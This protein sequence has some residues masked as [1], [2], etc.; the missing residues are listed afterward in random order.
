MR[1]H[2]NTT[3]ETTSRDIGPDEAVE[4]DGGTALPPDSGGATA[5]AVPFTA[6]QLARI[7]QI[8]QE[9]G[10]TPT[11][12]VQRLVEEGLEARARQSAA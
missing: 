2:S 11:E 8:A 3:M 10:I 4:L 9:R 6:E 1:D 12:A 7:E 5:L